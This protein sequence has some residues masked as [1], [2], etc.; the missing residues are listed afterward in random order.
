[1]RRV[2]LN[3]DWMLTGSAG[4]FQ[5]DLP[6]QVHDVLLENGCIKNPN[7]SGLNKDIWIGRETWKYEKEFFA[8]TEKGRW[9]L[10][11]QGIDTF[12]EICLNGHIIF[13]S[14]WI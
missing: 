1:M 6:A 4:V 9:N 5:T 10:C 14:N 2:N 13:R 7:I 12:A 11:F 3:K 8:E